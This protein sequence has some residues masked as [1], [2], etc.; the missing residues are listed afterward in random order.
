MNNADFIGKGDFV[1]RGSD[2]P[3]FTAS[4]GPYLQDNKGST[5]FDAE[6]A[7]GTAMLGYDTS[8]LDEAMDKI[9]GL[10]SLPSFCESELRLRV[11]EKLGRKIEESTGQ[12][13]RIAFE[14]GGAQGMELALK[15]VKLNT[16]KTQ[17]IVFQGAYHGRSGFTSQLSASHRYRSL[18]GDWRIPVTRLPLPDYALSGFPASQ[19]EWRAWY[20]QEVDK[21]L[22]SEI[23]GIASSKGGHDIAAFIAEPI[24]NVGGMVQPDKLL[25]EGI[26]KKFKKAGAL[27]I[28]DEI[29][30]GFYRTGKA[31]GFEHY[32]IDPDLIVMSK[33]LT[34]GLAPLSCVWA[35]EPLLDEHHFPPGTHSATF[36][37]NIMSLAVADTVLDR[38]AAWHTIEA[39]I[40][41]LQNAMSESIR[42][43]CKK[44]SIAQSGYALGGLARI[45][46]NQPRATEVRSNA[47]HIR[48]L[49]QGCLQN[50]Q[51]PT[52]CE[53][54]LL[55]STGMTP[56]IINL[57]PPLNMTDDQIGEFQSLLEACIPTS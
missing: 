35:K 47:L 11:A 42:R 28:M 55:A 12:Y 53:G 8:I 19:E 41:K 38:Y 14:T 6:A 46:L 25:F 3:V 4:H 48:S 9:R 57:H 10:P 39:D 23:G 56:N 5:Y 50:V 31:F 2:V 45:V 17:F 33:G 52:H 24:L 43:I 44:S 7:N 1:Y 21:L 29:F 15:I 30:C 37:N 54:M 22:T 27:I 32:V 16:Q 34:N 51:C 20:L 26:I 18:L 36:V 13:G 49:A 40:S